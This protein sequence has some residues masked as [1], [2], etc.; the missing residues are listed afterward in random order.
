[1]IQ[2]TNNVIAVDA[3][4][5]AKISGYYS[6]IKPFTGGLRVRDWLAGQ[7]YETQYQFGIDVLKMYGVL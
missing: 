5:H 7:S 3:A 2:N 1:M 4:T 6:S